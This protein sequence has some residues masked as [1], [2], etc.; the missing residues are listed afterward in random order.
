MNIFKTFREIF[1]RLSWWKKADRLGPDMLTTHFL[2]YIPSL[3]RKL[4]RRKFKRFDT[5]SEFRPGAY[6][7]NCSNISRG[8]M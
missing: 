5:G 4:C 3:S 1:S 6:A 8:K 7:I 2:L